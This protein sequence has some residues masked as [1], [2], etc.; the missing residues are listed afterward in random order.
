M[1][2]TINPILDRAGVSSVF[3]W[4]RGCLL[5]ACDFAHCSWWDLSVYSSQV[6]KSSWSRSWNES[7]CNRTPDVI[8][9]LTLRFTVTSLTERTEKL[10]IRPSWLAPTE[11][12]WWRSPTIGC[13]LH[14]K[15]VIYACSYLFHTYL[16]E[17]HR[18]HGSDSYQLPRARH[19]MKTCRAYRQPRQ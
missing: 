6:L 16:W 2:K 17:T 15:S 8:G 13:F 4:L 18:S 5:M 7:H 19:P 14:P 11:P 3:I 10:T 12:Q 9:F 1:L